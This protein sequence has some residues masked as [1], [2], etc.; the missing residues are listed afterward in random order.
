MTEDRDGLIAVIGMAGRFPGADTLER[1]WE[2]LV[3]GADVRTT[4]TDEE[5]AGIIPGRLLKNEQYVKI[6][7]VL[8]KV[9]GFDADFFVFTPSEAEELD[10]QQRLFL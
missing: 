8:G 9:F 7:Y 1:F 2:N 5:L 10:P 6:C 4:F 3:S